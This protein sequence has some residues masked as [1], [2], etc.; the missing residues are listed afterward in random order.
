MEDTTPKEFKV[1]NESVKDR[2]D[3]LDS[4]LDSYTEH[5][6]LNKIGLNVEAQQYLQLDYAELSSYNT[7]ECN[8]A[9]YALDRYALYL[10]KESNR[11]QAK[12][13]WALEN[14]TKI[15]G[16]VG[17]NYG[18]KWTKYEMRMSMVIQDN[19][20]AGALHTITMEMNAKI[21]ELSY[22]SKNVS[23]ISNTLKNLGRSKYESSRTN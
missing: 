2:I 20:Y 11:N 6:G 8:I 3:T 18:D 23:S 22:I 5:V 19:E 16:K 10:Q 1:S 15:V 7:E 14:I 17:N 13:N 21:T 12:Y 4:F 9:A